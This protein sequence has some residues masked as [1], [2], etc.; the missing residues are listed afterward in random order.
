MLIACLKRS[1]TTRSRI[2]HAL[3]HSE[4]EIRLVY[5]STRQSVRNNTIVFTLADLPSDLYGVNRIKSVKV[6]FSC[7]L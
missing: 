2:L 4:I 6:M 7:E 3:T 1:K 5:L